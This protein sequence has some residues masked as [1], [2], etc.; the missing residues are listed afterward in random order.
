M[1]QY[2]RNM[3]HIT[4]HDGRAEKVKKLFESSV[5]EQIYEWS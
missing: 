3:I 1:F 5:M 4:T 2:S